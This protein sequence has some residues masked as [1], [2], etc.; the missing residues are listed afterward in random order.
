MPELTRTTQT[1]LD[2]MSHAEKDALI[3]SLFDVLEGFG[4][5]LNELDGKVEMTASIQGSRRPWTA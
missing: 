4:H 5:R 3:L 2:R 1:E